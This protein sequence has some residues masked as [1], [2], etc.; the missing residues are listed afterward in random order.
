[1]AIDGSL[2]RVPRKCGQFFI[3]LHNETLPIVVYASAIHLFREYC[4]RTEATVEKCGSPALRVGELSDFSISFG[5]RDSAVWP[6]T[7][8]VILKNNAESSLFELLRDVFSQSFHATILRRLD[9][10]G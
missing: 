4:P 8:Q 6:A 7:F 3:G 9:D 1:V 10:N 5:P 2:I